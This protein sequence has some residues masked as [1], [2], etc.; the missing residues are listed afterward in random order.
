M[1]NVDNQKKDALMVFDIIPNKINKI[2][3]S[4]ITTEAQERQ[5][6]DKKMTGTS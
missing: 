4:T 3:L 6:R 1:R 5:R 2:K